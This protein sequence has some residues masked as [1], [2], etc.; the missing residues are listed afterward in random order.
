MEALHARVF[1]VLEPLTL[2][3]SVNFAFGCGSRTRGLHE[4]GTRKR[5]AGLRPVYDPA[6]LFRDRDNRDDRD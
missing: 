3:R 5:L 1:L 4:P 2:G 6:S